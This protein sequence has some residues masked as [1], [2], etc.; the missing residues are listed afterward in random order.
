MGER[1]IGWKAIGLHIG[2]DARTARRWEAERGLPVNRIPGK[3]GV[4]VWADSDELDRWFGAARA[5]APAQI[6]ARRPA[7]A[8]WVAGAGLFL[9][10]GAALIAFLPRQP[11][12]PA[13]H[14]LP[15]G[16]DRAANELYSAATYAREQRTAAGL[17][18]AA[19]LF[20][21]LTRTHPDKAEGFV[22]LAETNRLLRE[23]HSLPQETAYR[24]AAAAAQR[25]L[26]LQPRNPLALRALG[27]IRYWS[28]GDLAGGLA[29]LERARDAAPGD[30][31]SWHWY[32]T[33]LLGAGRFAEA[34]AALAEA[35]R[36]DPASSAM[37]ADEAWA[38][39]MAGDPAGARRALRAVIGSDPGFSG[40][41]LYLARLSLVA[42]DDQ[43][44]LRHLA[45]AARLR[46]DKARMAVAEAGRD[47][48]AR[49]GRG[50]MLRAIIR[51]ESEA[52]EQSGESAIRLAHWHAAAGDRLG[53]LRWLR[54]AETIREPEIRSQASAVELLPYRADPAFAPYLSV[55]NPRS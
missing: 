2:R 35:R 21:E 32:G 26:E 14:P 28:E 38:R 42:G 3:G 24:R 4:T 6:D 18:E 20:G 27:F 41:H 8:R 44:F 23:F 36:L 45:E 9:A 5:E 25:A 33:A 17:R 43:A 46:Q 47:G 19:R 11:A 31:K 39:H 55:V 50:E 40:A 7:M 49:G 30:A 13:G 16:A 52:F 48:F 37:A 29:L 15:Y 34:R 10:A 22:G 51:A 54:R 53:A 1:L 12:P